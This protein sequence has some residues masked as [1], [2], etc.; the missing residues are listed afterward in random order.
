M[1]DEMDRA[2]NSWDRKPEGRGCLGDDILK[3]FLDK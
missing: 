1:E 2:C 3:W